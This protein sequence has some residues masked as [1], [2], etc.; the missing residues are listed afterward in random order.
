MAVERKKRCSLCQNE[1]QVF[2]LLD[3]KV[4]ILVKAEMLGVE[5]SRLETR[6]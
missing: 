2:A 3:R 5:E 6:V 4:M 1:E